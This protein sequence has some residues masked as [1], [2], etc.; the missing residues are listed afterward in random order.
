MKGNENER[1]L[2]HQKV[3]E[4][5]TCSECLV[6]QCVFSMNSIVVDDGPLQEVFGKLKQWM[7]DGYMYDSKVRV[8][9]FCP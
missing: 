9:V 3:W 2:L 4:V 7:E 6:P 8:K 1:C 5:V